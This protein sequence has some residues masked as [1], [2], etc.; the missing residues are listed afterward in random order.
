MSEEKILNEEAL[1]AV[2]GGAGDTGKTVTVHCDCGAQWTVQ[3][4]TV[5]AVCPQCGKLWRLEST[6]FR[7]PVYDP[8]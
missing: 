1:D 7:P 2:T 4:G 8:E 3:K 6:G 5:N